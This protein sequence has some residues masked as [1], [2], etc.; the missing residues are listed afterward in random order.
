MRLQRWKESTPE[1]GSW[2]GRWGGTPQLFSVLNGLRRF[3]YIRA[4]LPTARELAE[5]LLSLAQSGHDPAL[6]VLAHQALGVALWS[7]AELVSAREHLGRGPTLYDPQQHR[8]YTLL[9]GEDPGVICPSFATWVL[10]LLGYPDQAL[11]RSCEALTLAEELSHPLSLALAL[12]FAAW[13]HQLRGERQAVQER[14]ERAI[15]LTSEHGLAFWLA[16]GTIVGGWTLVEQGQGEAGIAQMRQGLAAYRATGANVTVTYFLAL[17]AEAYRKMGQAEEGLSV[18]TEALTAVDRT[19][20][21]MYEAELYRLKGELTLAQS[22]VQS[23]ASSVRN[24]QS[25]AEACFHKAIEIARRRQA[26]SLEL[27]AATSLARLWQQQGKKAEAHELLSEIY[28]WFTE[29]FDTKDLQEAKG[30]LEEL[31]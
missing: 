4:E 5:Q 3:Y 15:P 25:E 23:L 16:Q 22:S 21:R 13:L 6:L 7:L 17:L 14:V 29:G 10:W 2:A 26:K 12:N 20:E 24:P 30:L 11:E 27:R 8:F 19:G 28:N 9:Y 18:L 31:A 1:H